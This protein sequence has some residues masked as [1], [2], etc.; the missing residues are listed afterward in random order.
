MAAFFAAS[1]VGVMLVG[2][3]GAL[4]GVH[5]YMDF[6]EYIASF[7]R[8]YAPNSKEYALR[9]DIFYQEAQKIQAHNAKQSR[10]W[11]AQINHLTDLTEVEFA[12]MQGWNGGSKGRSGQGVQ[13][14]QV[15]ESEQ[16]ELRKTVDWRNLSSMQEK[17]N[18]GH[19]GSCWAFAT[20][21]MLMAN[22]E[23][24]KQ[25]VRTFSAQEL[26]DCVLNEKECGGT[27]GCHGGTAEVAMQYI[28]EHGLADE[29][30]RPYFAKTGTCRQA[31]SS[32]LSRRTRP[33]GIG[34]EE[35]RGHDSSGAQLGLVGWKTLPENK[36]EPLM[37]AV[38]QGPVA[39]SVAATPWKGY[40]GGVFDGCGQDT[41]L[42]TTLG[43]AVLL[44]GYG[45]EPIYDANYWTVL[46]SW[47]GQ[48]GESGHIRLLRGNSAEEDDAYCGTDHAP[49]KGVEC[50]PYRDQ[51]K[52][53]GMCGMLYDSVAVVFN[54]Q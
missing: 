35:H 46:N 9:R 15:M 50:K 19:C 1:A 21:S 36:A 24:K 33:Q 23:I 39:I 18:Q 17:R 54:D 7:G 53:C 28:T 43:H 31:S 20:T 47:G 29:E 12:A 42:G 16:G 25:H 41:T 49:E 26:L 2:S 34:V 11:T 8:S 5:E 14:N 37:R 45:H 13:L 44:M 30:T 3:H 6:D 10:L 40:Q 32:F 52:V 38:T 48:W 51:V 4:H 27:G 22:Y